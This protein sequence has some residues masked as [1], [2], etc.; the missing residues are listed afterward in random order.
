MSVF[1]NEVI[2]PL[3]DAELRAVPVPVS[4]AFFPAT[5]PVSGTVSVGNF[6]A[7]QP[8][9]GTV[10]ATQGTSPWVISGT[11]STSGSSVNVATVSTANVSTTVATLLAS[12]PARIKFIVYNETGTLFVKCGA[13]ATAADYSMRLTANTSWEFAGY[14]GIL[15]AIKQTGAS[16]A[17]VTSF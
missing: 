3:T 8:V 15:T 10:A 4:G 13:G 1:T 7:T 17:Q 12:A 16:T 6:P 5:Q 11:V 9:S 2:G 14:S